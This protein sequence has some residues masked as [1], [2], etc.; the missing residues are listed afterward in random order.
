MVVINACESGSGTFYR[1]EGMLSL[2]RSFLL[3]GAKSVVNAL[4]PVDDK[5]GSSMMISFYKNLAKGQS[6]SQALRK[7]KLRYL[8]HASPSFAHPYY[9]A[10]YQMTGN[11]SPLFMSRWLKFSGLA[12]ILML[13]LIF[14][15]RKRRNVNRTISSGQAVSRSL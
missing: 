8:E 15:L 9:W 13:I 12:G 5:A 10:G 3:A 14:S 11:R 1:G 6:K 2:S 7:A 4:W